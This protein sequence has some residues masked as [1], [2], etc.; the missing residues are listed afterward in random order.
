MNYNQTRDT[1]A[2]W[3]MPTYPRPD[4][5]LTRGEGSW[6]WDHAGA[7]YLDFTCGIS[8]CNLGHCHPR[9]SAAIKEQCDKLVHVSNLFL[10]ENQALLAEQIARRAFDGRVFFGNSGAEANEGMIKFA[11]KWGHD[12]GKFEI[13]AADASF[14]GRTLCSLAATGRAKY[15]KGFA[16]DM[17]GFKHIPFN[18]IAALNAAITD[19]TVAILLE[20]IQGEGGIIPADPD[21]LTAVR[22][23]CDARNILL[24]FDEVQSG[25]GRSGT[26]FAFQRYGVTP[27]AMSMAKAIANGFPM[28]AFIVK[29]EFSETLTA[30]THASTFGG[31]PL[32]CAAAL[33]VLEVFDQENILENVARRGELAREKLNALKERHASVTEI[34]GHGLMLGVVLDREA[35]GVIPAARKQG[36]LIIT[37]G[38]NV[39]RF[40]PPLNVTEKDLLEGVERLDRALGALEGDKPV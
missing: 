27:D 17:P 30:G 21:Y 20:P 19:Q 38:E 22:A 3:V 6:V 13:I 11:R 15:R 1:Y 10:T 40:Y 34:R 26:F 39:I 12:Q 2:K 9:V 14:H 23:L 28:G 4:L 31:T 24:L 37:A 7:A 36:L 16:P 8:V 5:C 29:R 33:A 18:D 35:A 32:A 25:F